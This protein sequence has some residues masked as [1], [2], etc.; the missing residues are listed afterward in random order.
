MELIWASKDFC[1]GSRSYPG[2]PL[3]LTDDMVGF[4]PANLFLRHFLLRGDIGSEGSWAIIGRALYD[5]FSFL[6]A[7]D[8]D[9]RDVDRGDDKTIIAVYRDYSIVECGL[10]INTVRQRLYYLCI[11]YE[12]ALKRGWIPRLP[13]NHETRRT[14]KKRGFLVHISSRREQSLVSDLLPKKPKNLPKYLTHEQI[15]KLMDSITN[16]HHYMI[17]KFALQ[18]GL[19]RA[20]LATFP[21]SYILNQ[22]QSARNTR[23]VTIRLDPYDGTGMMTKGSK[24][25]EIYIPRTLLADTYNYIQMTRG[26]RSSLSS[27]ASKALFVN[28]SGI[29]YAN[30]GKGI[31]RI[32]RTNGMK[33][34]I[35]LHP[36]ML[37]HTYATHTLRLLQKTKTNL[38]PLVFLQRQLGHSSIE[39]TMIYLG[40]LNEDAESATLEYFDE[41]VQDLQ[42]QE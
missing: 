16:P 15:H 12:F 9:W 24:T 33:A 31:E 25:R 42:G 2:F 37:R 41:I 4:T 26:E 14:I 32:V 8:F 36:H 30:N 38:D 35:K 3:L 29:P 7:N 34:G 10:A 17:I 40:L 1:I 39:T 19:R 6:Q 22:A 20:E 27:T 13:F 5:F 28:S 11:F 23:N 21:L 18:T